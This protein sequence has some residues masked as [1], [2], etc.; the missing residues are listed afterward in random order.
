MGQEVLECRG[1][2]ADIKAC[3]SSASIIALGRAFRF[4][5]LPCGGPQETEFAFKGLQIGVPLTAD[6]GLLRGSP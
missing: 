6:S 2:F 3:S 5:L 4:S 1:W